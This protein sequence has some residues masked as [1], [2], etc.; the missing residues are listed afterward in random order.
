MTPTRTHRFVRILLKSFLMT[1]V[2]AGLLFAAILIQ[3]HRAK[4]G[5][6]INIKGAIFDPITFFKIPAQSQF[7][8]VSAVEVIALT[9]HSRLGAGVAPLT[10]STLLTRAAQLKAEDMASKE[11]YAHVS[12]DG[13]TPLYWLDLVGYRYQNAGENLVVDRT[14]SSDVVS[15]WLASPDHRENIERPQFTE[16][17]VGTA[18]GVYKGLQTIYVVQEFGKPLPPIAQKPTVTQ[19]ITASVTK[20]SASVLTL[21]Q[22]DPLAEK[23]L[24]VTKPLI[25]T[26]SVPKKV[27]VKKKLT[28]A[29]PAQKKLLPLATP[30]RI[31]T[32]VASTSLTNSG[33]DSTSLATSTSSTSLELFKGTIEPPKNTSGSSSPSNKIEPVVGESKALIP[34]I[35]YPA[36]EPV[37]KVEKVSSSSALLNEFYTALDYVRKTFNRTV[38][39]KP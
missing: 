32:L 16:I 21:P 39:G 15:A 27:V 2:I 13:K 29:F 26:Y 22:E 12:P 35:L 20:N 1:V 6:S 5:S 3:K 31:S 17:G 34:V 33:L 25:Q 30:A 24:A 8:S 23:V 28:A 10:T 37:G 14:T 36:I 19:T 38:L 11:Y 7:A 4:F 18:E 9:N